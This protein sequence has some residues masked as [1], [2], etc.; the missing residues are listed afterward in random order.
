MKMN[1]LFIKQ[2][3]ELSGSS[4]KE[5]VLTKFNDKRELRLLL[6][7]NRFQVTCS[8]IYKVGVISY[9][10]LHSATELIFPAN[11]KIISMVLDKGRHTLSVAEEYIF[12]WAKS[13]ILQE[14]DFIQFEHKTELKA[15][16]RIV[17]LGGTEIRR[18]FEYLPDVFAILNYTSDSFS[19]GGQ[20]NSIES[21]LERI[22]VHL[23]NNARIIDL[24]VESTR[25]GFDVGAGSSKAGATKINGEQEVKFLKEI[26]PHVI[27]L[28]QP[29]MFDLSIDTYHPD[30]VRWLLDQ[31]VDIINDV[32]GKLPY[33]LVKL[34][35]SSGKRYVA[36]HS[37]TMPAQKN[38][39]L[40]ESIHPIAYIYRWMESKIRDLKELNIDLQK[41]IL[42]PG[43]GFGLSL[44]QSWYVVRQ[45][46]QF[47][48]LPCEIMLGHSRKV[49]FSHV[50]NDMPQNRDLDTAIIARDKLDSIDYIRLHDLKTFNQIAEIE[51]Y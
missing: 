16:S 36:M 30:T 9:V 18:T 4:S 42:D 10:L 33:E 39:V 15:S 24:G 34:I 46:D 6:R 19:D 23:A 25:P 47:K 22:N 32:S 14:I 17:N 44:A 7:H 12:K 2:T 1:H 50:H 26:L 31:D 8:S 43:I 11:L 38:V 41:I 45:L 29:Q 48:N 27:A 21:A 3:Y 35:I 28:K 51:F 49:F 13:E 37:L 20:Y 5:L 40:D